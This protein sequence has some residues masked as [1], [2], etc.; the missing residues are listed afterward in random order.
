[1]ATDPNPET[2]PPMSTIIDFVPDFLA[3]KDDW[4][5]I[6]LKV[7]LSCGHTTVMPED[8]S[9]EIGDKAYCDVCSKSKSR[10]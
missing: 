8:I 10:N 9:P 6:Q 2:V 3:P 5:L 1:M 7:K 4:G